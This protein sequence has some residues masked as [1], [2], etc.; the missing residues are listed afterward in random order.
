MPTPR[1]TIFVGFIQKVV[2]PVRILICA[3]LAVCSVYEIY[4]IVGLVWF[5]RSIDGTIYWANVLGIVV[6]LGE[7][8]VDRCGGFL[9]SQSGVS[10]VNGSGNQSRDLSRDSGSAHLWFAMGLRGNLDP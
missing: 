5:V 7:V 2:Q 1:S 8:V 3:V 10:Y 9:V 6:A 4:I